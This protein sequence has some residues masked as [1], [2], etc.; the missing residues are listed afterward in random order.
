MCFFVI[1]ERADTI[2]RE[3]DVAQNGSALLA[4]SFAYVSREA[5]NS[6]HF[7]AGHLSQ[8]IYQ[9]FHKASHYFAEETGGT[10]NDKQMATNMTILSPQER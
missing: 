6:L 4:F 10:T 1:V 7:T 5:V 9:E 3:L 8:L 2:G